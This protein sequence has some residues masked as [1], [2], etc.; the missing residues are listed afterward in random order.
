MGATGNLL[1]VPGET[2]SALRKDPSL[3]EK[4]LARASWADREIRLDGK[5][6][7]IPAFS[8]EFILALPTKQRRLRALRW[9]RE[10]GLLVPGPP[11]QDPELPPP[12]SGPPLCLYKEWQCL[13]YLFCGTIRRV[14]SPRGLAIL[15]D[16]PIGPDLGYGRAR[17]LDAASVRRVA[18]ELARLPKE[19]IRTRYAPSAMARRRVY[20]FEKWNAESDS[21]A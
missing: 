20:G 15:G 19:T 3:V 11:P 17:F 1:R 2:L 9:Q 8:L 5:P 12:P 18:R 4:F 13:H 14:K 6:Y 21:R 7:S 10:K 16:R